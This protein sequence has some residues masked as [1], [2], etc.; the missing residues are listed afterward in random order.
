MSNI[1]GI[2]DTGHL[3]RT[4]TDTTANIGGQQ[5]R[6]SFGDKVR[7]AL[8]TAG[9]AI[10]SFFHGLSERYDNWKEGR[11]VATATTKAN[12]AADGIIASLSGGHANASTLSNLSA[13]AKAC[14]RAGLDASEVLGLKVKS[15]PE[16]ERNALLHMDFDQVKTEARDTTRQGLER[17]ANLEDGL[18]SSG[19]TSKDGSETRAA[20]P[21]AMNRAS[22][23]IESLRQC[24][25]Q[26]KI[27]LINEMGANLV[28]M[29]DTG[30]LSGH[31]VDPSLPGSLTDTTRP[32][33]P[34]FGVPKHNGLSYIDSR[35]QDRMEHTGSKWK[36]IGDQGIELHSDACGDWHR[37]NITF[38]KDNG[39]SLCT[40]LQPDELTDIE[41]SERIPTKLENSANFLNDIT[42]DP[43]QTKVLSTVLHQYDLRSMVSVMGRPDGGSIQFVATKGGYTDVT[44]THDDGQ[45]DHHVKPGQIGEADIQL[46]KLPNGNYQVSVDWEYISSGLRSFDE[47]NQGSEFQVDP[48]NPTHG[49]SSA[50]EGTQPYQ[51]MQVKMQGQFEIDGAEA[52]QGR[53]KILT[54][55]GFI[56]D[57]S[58]K[59]A[60][61]H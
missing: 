18:K 41:D 8:S 32:P 43:V 6:A 4:N 3:T 44:V 27:E 42:G 37:M 26:V 24:V 47:N 49:A 5:A 40:R 46:S 38:N 45:V 17:A 34:R 36:E 48:K 50:Q 14:D 7:S 51:A 28:T 22:D 11:A 15:M 59:F 30:H 35:A 21:G 29:S 60:L 20:I 58:G 53:I 33:D 10:T 1:G 57:I 23:Q 9:N 52:A 12:T 39:T 25:A 19:L 2:H 13:L 55:G 56:H 61:P 54:G 16:G 31:V